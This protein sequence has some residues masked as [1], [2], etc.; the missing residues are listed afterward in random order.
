[1]EG[2][3]RSKKTGLNQFFFIGEKIRTRVI[4][5]GPK[6]TEPLAKVHFDVHFFWGKRS[7]ERPGG[8]LSEVLDQFRWIIVLLRTMK[9]RARKMPELKDELHEWATMMS[10]YTRY[11]DLVQTMNKPNKVRTK[12]ELGFAYDNF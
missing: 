12:I 7:M 10:Y 8:S 3:S 5:V 9:I 4:L 1:M 11:T 6:K 2:T